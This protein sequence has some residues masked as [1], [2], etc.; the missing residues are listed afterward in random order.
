MVEFLSQKNQIN[1]QG[2]SKVSK[3]LSWLRWKI[4][5]LLWYKQVKQQDSEM[6][7]VGK[8]EEYSRVNSKHVHVHGRADTAQAELIARVENGWIVWDL[9]TEW[10]AEVE[11]ATVENTVKWEEVI[12]S[13]RAQI[14]NLNAKRAS[15][16]RSKVKNITIS[17]EWNT[18]IDDS[19][20]GEIRW[21]AKIINIRAG[22]SV[23]KIIGADVVN[24]ENGAEVGE[25]IGTNEVIVAKWWKTGTIENAQAVFHQW[26][27]KR[28]SWKD[29]YYTGSSAN[30]TISI[31]WVW[32]IWWKADFI[33]T[34]SPNIS[35][36][37]TDGAKLH[38]WGKINS[39]SSGNPY[40]KI[41]LD[42]PVWCVDMYMPT[43]RSFQNLQS[44][45]GKYRWLTNP[46][47]YKD[48]KNAYE[49]FMTAQ[50]QVN[51]LKISPDIKGQRVN[52]YDREGFRKAA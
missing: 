43:N 18:D 6:F 10:L 38:A 49:D 51:T 15:I 36:S 27:A 37:W 28:I 2:G 5:D 12:T 19:K 52:Y 3:F 46:D 45:R 11:N 9:T 29:V 33:T 16:K 20:V 26:K 23:W 48:I 1:P 35:H 8:G 22:S 21:K 42:K 7:V 24:V 25:I 41:N 17:A 30:A 31:W 4:V 13:K 39:I 50:E 47:S 14:Y 34:R 32:S 40:D 44:K